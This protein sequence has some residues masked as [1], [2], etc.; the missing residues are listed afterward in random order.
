MAERV[1]ASVTDGESTI[2]ERDRELM[3]EFEERLDQ[4]MDEEANMLKDMNKEKVTTYSVLLCFTLF[5]FHID[6]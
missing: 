6:S 2:E 1:E 3:R 4:P 5:Q